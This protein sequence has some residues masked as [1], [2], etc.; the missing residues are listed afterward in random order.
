VDPEILSEESKA[1]VEQNGPCL[2]IASI[3]VAENE[4]QIFKIFSPPILNDREKPQIP[5]DGLYPR[6]HT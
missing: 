6:S 2:T 4:M 5:I 1:I 3:P